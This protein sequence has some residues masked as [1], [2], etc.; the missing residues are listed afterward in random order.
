MCEAD[1]ARAAADPGDADDSAEMARRLVF[2]IRSLDEGARDYRAW[3]IAWITTYSVLTVGQGVAVGVVSAVIENRQERLA[4]QRAY[5]IGAGASALGVI[6]A[7]IGYSAAIHGA[8]Q[9]RELRDGTPAG[10]ARAL[11]RAEAVVRGAAAKQRFGRSWLVHAGGAAVNVAIALVLWLALDE[12]V[13]A[14]I[15]LGVGI[16]VSQT[17]IW[18]QPMR[19]ARDWA[20][21]RRRFRRAAAGLPAAPPRPRL[22]LA[23]FPGGLGLRL[24]W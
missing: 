24:T 6:F 23:P 1:N 21:Y 5:A 12:P 3:W 20:A 19:A 2:L 7:G 11:A 14:G 18:T 8:E 15:Q 17:Q 13:N 9:I 10:E 16:A 22:A 4:S